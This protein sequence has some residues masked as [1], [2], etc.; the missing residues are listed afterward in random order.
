MAETMLNVTLT[1]RHDLSWTARLLFRLTT[2]AAQVHARK[3]TQGW[4][5]LRTALINSCLLRGYQGGHSEVKST[6]L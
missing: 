2:V 6:K 3:Y 5:E 1:A 4:A